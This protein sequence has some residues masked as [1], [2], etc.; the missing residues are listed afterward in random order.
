MADSEFK[1]HTES[2]DK[3]KKFLEDLERNISETDDTVNHHKEEL[4]NL[5]KKIP[6]TEKS[7]EEA[8]KDLRNIKMKESQLIDSISK[9]KRQLEEIK[10]SMVASKSRSRVLDALMQQKREGKCPGLFGRL[11][12]LGAI[13]LK[14]DVAISTACGPLDH[15]VVDTVETAVW[16]IEFLKKHD[17]GRAAIIALEKQQNLWKNI[18]EPIQTYVLQLEIFSELI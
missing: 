16:C 3:H 8:T 12:D 5:K 7:L 13:D 10:S 2:E 4:V 11:G 9:E 14:Y 18:N 15:L 17:I 6:L 1:L